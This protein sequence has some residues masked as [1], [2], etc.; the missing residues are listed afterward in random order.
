MDVNMFCLQVEFVI[1][2]ER[3]G[4][5]IVTVQRSGRG[6]RHANLGNEILQPQ[7]ILQ[8]VSHRDV[9]SFC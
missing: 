4:A 2:S 7:N 6:D 3:D 5:L 9:L 1:E 8:C